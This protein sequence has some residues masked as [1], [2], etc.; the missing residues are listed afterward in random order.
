MRCVG[1]QN[2][3][4]ANL[5]ASLHT[6]DRIR[7]VAYLDDDVGKIY[8]I[9]EN[10][11]A[12]DV[13]HA[14]PPY[15]QLRGINIS[16]LVDPTDIVACD[17]NMLLYVSDHTA[18]CVWQVTTGGK[19]DFRL[20]T[21]WSPA[22]QKTSAVYPVSLSVRFGRLVVVETSKVL[23]YDSHD[24]K[25]DEINKFP[26][27]ATLYHG[28]ETD[29]NTFLVALS[30]KNHSTVQEMEKDGKGK[31]SSVR[32]WQLRSS[33]TSAQPLYMA[34][35]A[36]DSLYVVI[37][38]SSKV[39]VLDK[40]LNEIRSVR[41]NKRSVP[42]RLCLLTQRVRRKVFLLAGAGL[43]V[44]IYDGTTSALENAKIRRHVTV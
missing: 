19:V 28:V 7:G 3:Q 1:L 9:C 32:E 40:A 21:S 37:H 12:I 25:L 10:S 2:C 5:K 14:I 29:H 24:D 20:P 22:R 11:N 13:F 4:R 41:L 34:W 38:D 17:T 39:L 33:N 30:D 27:S 8:I 15:E 16:R 42:T 35:D 26:V 44:N 36:F 43:G 18:G 23:I 6:S 31:W